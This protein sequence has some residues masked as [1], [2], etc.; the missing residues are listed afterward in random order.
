M[1]LF[2]SSSLLFI[3][4]ALLI[5]GE[6]RV[7]AEGRY[8][9][10]NLG[11][12]M[13]AKTIPIEAVTVNASGQAVAW[14]V[15][16]DPDHFEAVGLDAATGADIRL[17]L[18][19]YK[20]SSQIRIMRGRSGHLYI[21]AGSPA[22]F[23]KYD[24]DRHE[25]IDL[26]RPAA[27]ARYI[28]GH[29]VAPDGRFYVGSYP[30]T[31]FVCVDTTTD[32]T[33]SIGPIA[34]DKRQKYIIEPATSDDNIVYIPV[35]LHH[36]ELWTYDPVTGAKR[37]VLPESLTQ[38]QGTVWV[39]V[40]DDGQVYGT[41][42]GR[43][44]RCYPD[45]I[46][47]VDELPKRRD[48]RSQITVAGVEYR[49]IDP[50]GRLVIHDTRSGATRFVQTGVRGESVMIYSIGGIHDGK[51]WG[52]G[53]SPARTWTLDLQTGKFEDWGR[54]VRPKTQV[55]DT[56]F[57]ERGVFLSSY[58]GADIDLLDPQRR[59]ITHVVSLKE[60]H[61]GQERLPHFVLGPD[62]NIYGPTM[63]VKGHLDGGIVRVDPETLA[64]AWFPI[65][66]DLAPTSLVVVPGTSELFGTATIHSSTSVVPTRREG[67]VFIWDIEQ[68]KVVWEGSPVPGTEH[69]RWA[70]MGR[71]G[72]VYG[73]T[74]THYFVFD[75]KARRVVHVGEL[76]LPDKN[77]TVLLAPE[78]TGPEGLIV[79]LLRGRVF[80]IDPR[81]HSVRVLAEHPSIL[82]D[83]HVTEHTTLAIW[84]SPEGVLYYGAGPELWRVNLVP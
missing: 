52:G 71:N 7:V 28:N 38:H 16:V 13:E 68:E 57:H 6:S 48:E 50:S 73:I 26:G 66:D 29:T 74:N 81:D 37:Q 78:P 39:F 47:L 5:C 33:Y 61:H 82:R 17:D 55:Y 45:R 84:A 67:A 70:T 49:E 23:F 60:T 72:L 58:L 75:P 34:E 77:L 59:Q 30:A 46:E 12:P 62:G 25:L 22:R 56:F 35:G 8:V 69:Y 42:F 3:A 18:M 21:Y 63:P 20:R 51:L 80:A 40:A 10:E 4:A 19:R 79:G 32:Q 43:S 15:R 41:G 36:A 53:F 83:E 65:V 31:N 27:P 14:G 44:F 1:A 11:E 24:I 9:F 64:C 2:R 54:L 76:P